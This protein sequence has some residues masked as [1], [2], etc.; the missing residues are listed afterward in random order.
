MSERSGKL[1]AYRGW[2]LNTGP[3]YPSSLPMFIGTELLPSKRDCPYLL[4]FLL[5]LSRVH[6]LPAHFTVPLCSGDTLYHTYSTKKVHPLLT[7]RI[8]T[9]TLLNSQ[10]NYCTGVRQ[11]FLQK[12]TGMCFFFLVSLCTKH[13]QHPPLFPGPQLCDFLKS[14]T[15]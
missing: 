3:L 14:L 2:P 5:R 11:S 6:G 12:Q 13:D 7:L 15:F 8:Y 4:K 1:A 9:F 10:L